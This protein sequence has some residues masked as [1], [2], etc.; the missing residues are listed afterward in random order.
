MLPKIDPKDFI[1]SNNPGSAIY[2]I[3]RRPE[4]RVDFLVKE[5]S[6]IIKKLINPIVSIK[7]GLYHYNNVTLVTVMFLIGTNMDQLFETWFNY[8]ATGGQGQTAFSLMTTQE[9]IGFHLYG[10]SNKVEKGIVIPNN[11]K[12]KEF[13][14]NASKIISQIPPWGMAEFDKERE[15]LYKK[16]PTLEDLWK[17]LSKK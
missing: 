3:T 5:E 14:A 12:L 10:D 7:A 16:Y 13:F 1:I 6:S 15:I 2:C 8:H 4:Q 9:D 17:A 11:L